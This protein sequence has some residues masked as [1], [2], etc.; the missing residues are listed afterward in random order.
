MHESERRQGDQPRITSCLVVTYWEK[1][2]HVLATSAMACNLSRT[3]L[4][5]VCIATTKL[6]EWSNMF[7]AYGLASVLKTPLTSVYP[8]VNTRVRGMFNRETF[9]QIS[10]TE[11]RCSIPPIILWTHII[12]SKI[13]YQSM[14]WS[15]NHFVPCFHI[16]TL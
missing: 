5:L 9:P 15:P 4:H 8:D 1:M 16:Q 2:L 13:P 3:V 11:Q 7:H 10:D 6:G 12:I 14:Q